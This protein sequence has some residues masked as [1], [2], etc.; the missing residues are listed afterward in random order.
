MANK[1]PSSKLDEL[2]E[3]SAGKN[4]G[5]TA[6]YILANQALRDDVFAMFES[7]LTLLMDHVIKLND[8]VATCQK[9]LEDSKARERHRST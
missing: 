9:E 6:H 7:K 8:K 5:S 4:G 3:K 1:G 2:A